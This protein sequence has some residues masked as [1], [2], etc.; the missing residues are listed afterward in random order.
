M[1]AHD[2]LPPLS[3]GPKCPAV[4][5][6]WRC[7]AWGHSC[8]IS[9]SC[10]IYCSSVAQNAFLLEEPLGMMPHSHP[11]ITEQMLLPS[12]F[13]NVFLKER[14]PSTPNIKTLPF[15]KS[16]LA[17][18]S[19]LSL[20]LGISSKPQFIK[21]HLQCFMPVP[22]AHDFGV[23]SAHFLAPAR[24]VSWAQKWDCPQTAQ[25]PEP[26]SLHGYTFLFNYSWKDILIP[27]RQPWKGN[28]IQLIEFRTRAW[29][30]SSGTH[31]TKVRVY[32]WQ[33]RKSRTTNVSDS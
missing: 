17:L 16:A 27:P 14:E 18:P 6:D 25:C 26:A 2:G 4:P 13:Q 3:V 31:P 5:A 9:E 20:I 11:M 21:H 7:Q 19:E 22:R 15:P 28:R 1:G 24:E 33:R 32:S 10:H 29:A 12:G 30:A 23:C 8:L